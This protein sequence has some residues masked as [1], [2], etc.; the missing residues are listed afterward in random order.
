MESIEC[1][2]SISEL[3]FDTGSGVEELEKVLLELQHRA[4]H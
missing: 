3:G 2:K 4:E 1:L